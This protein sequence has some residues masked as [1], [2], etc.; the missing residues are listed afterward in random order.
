MKVSGKFSAQWIPTNVIILTKGIVKNALSECAGDS[1]DKR[2]CPKRHQVPCKNGKECIFYATES[3]EFLHDKL[4]HKAKNS[5]D[6]ELFN[7]RIK[8][9]E[10]RIF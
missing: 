4:L 8:S 6:S 2:A 1:E 3:C 7:N 10:E 9:I 5:I